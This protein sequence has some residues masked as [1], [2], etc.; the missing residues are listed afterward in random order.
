M[1][2]IAILIGIFSIACITACTNNK[3]FNSKACVND[4]TIQKIYKENTQAYCTCVEKNIQN[5]ANTI[6]MT[7]SII[8]TQKQSC[9]NEFT[10]L[11]TNF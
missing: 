8:E 4:E 10:T 7:D 6:V 5:I 9:A 2:T 3:Q 11:D 1:K